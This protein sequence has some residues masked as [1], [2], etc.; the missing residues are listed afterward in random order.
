MKGRRNAIARAL[1]S[2][3]F[4]RRVVKPRKG[5]GAYDRKRKGREDTSPPALFPSRLVAGLL[6]GDVQQDGRGGLD[7]RLRVDGVP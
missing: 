6:P 5:R 1:R 2:P 3:A 7:D 4:A